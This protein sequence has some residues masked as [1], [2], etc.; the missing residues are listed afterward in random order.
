MKTTSKIVIAGLILLINQSLFAQSVFPGKQ[1]IDKKEFFGLNLS[2][3]VAEKNLTTYWEDY[4]NEYGKVK[5]KRGT[6]TIDKAFIPTISASPVGVT[7]QITSTKAAAQVFLAVNVSGNFLT[8][9]ADSAYKATEEL[10]K[11]FSA[12]SALR[13]EV[14][15][16]DETYSESNK[17]HAK[18]VKDEERL[19][20]DIE[21]AEK[22]LAE[23]K[24]E[25]EKGKANIGAAVTDMQTKLQV[26]EASKA[27]LPASKK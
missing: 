3:S 17:N 12:Y 5:G 6:Y 15:V 19:A 11:D 16:A 7:S 23:M 26:L 18:L 27:K 21:K 20:K 4:M 1:T 14:R 8:N 9:P 25:L 13:E 10:L 22:K 24:E 2:S